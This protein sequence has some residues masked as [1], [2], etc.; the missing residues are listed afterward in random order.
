MQGRQQVVALVTH[1]GSCDLGA[2]IYK[3]GSKAETEH[4]KRVSPETRPHQAWLDP[5]S[6]EGG[7]Y[8]EALQGV[9]RWTKR[10]HELIH[11]RT[12]ERLGITQL[13]AF[14]N[15]HTFVWQRGDRYYHGKGATSAW[16]DETG[17]LLP[18]VSPL[19]MVDPADT[20]HQQRSLRILRAPRCRSRES[21]A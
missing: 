19:N 11:E 9:A 1:H 6:G 14:A 21:F 2:Q 17:H 18:G 10:N 16:T 13:A 15:E 4:T 3:R 20:R 8:W 12:A 7:A 5:D